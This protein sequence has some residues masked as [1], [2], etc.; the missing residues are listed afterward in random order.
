LKVNI[1]RKPT[2]ETK[3]PRERCKDGNGKKRWMT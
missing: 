1:L 3:E 2:K